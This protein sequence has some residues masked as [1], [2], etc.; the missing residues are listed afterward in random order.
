MKTTLITCMVLF[1]GMALAQTS[2]PDQQPNDP[3][4]ASSPHQRQVTKSSAAEATPSGGS[5]PDASAT[6]SQKDVLNKKHSAKHAKKKAATSSDQP[7]PP[8]Q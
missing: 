8:Q 6:P 7:T 4:A 2:T 1:A 5:Q 3:N